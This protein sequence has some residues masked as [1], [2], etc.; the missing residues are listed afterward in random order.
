MTAPLLVIADQ[1]SE[2]N[3]LRPRAV[4]YTETFR[5]LTGEDVSTFGG[6]AYDALLLISDAITRANS[7]DPEAVRDALETTKDLPGVTGMFNMSAE[8]HLGIDQSSL[9]M[10]TVRDSEWVLE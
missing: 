9:Y 2:D 1:L 8:D 10:V 4:E 7:D 5:D 3:P 6:Y